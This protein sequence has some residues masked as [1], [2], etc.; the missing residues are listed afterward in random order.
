MQNTRFI[1]HALIGKSPS[2][3]CLSST[4][5]PY[6][7]F[8]N[9]LLTLPEILYIYCSQVWIMGSLAPAMKLNPGEGEVLVSMREWGRTSFIIL[10]H[11]HSEEYMQKAF[12]KLEFGKYL[13]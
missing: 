11:P 6:L 9:F 1:G 4:Q 12:N 13:K 8:P 5:L 3:R 2:L 7:A 10:P